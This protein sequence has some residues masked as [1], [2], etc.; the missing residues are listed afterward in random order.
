MRRFLALVAFTSLA[1]LLLGSVP[2]RAQQDPA[3]RALHFL[4]T[5]QAAD[6]HVDGFDPNQGTEDYLLAAAAGGY[7]P[8]ALRN[9]T[10]GKSGY[11]YLTANVAAAT[12]TAGRSGRLLQAVVVAGRPTLFAGVDLVARLETVLYKPSTGQYGDSDSIS[13][14]LAIVGLKAAGRPIPAAALTFLKSLQ[15]P[16]GSWYAGPPPV[17]PVTVLGDTN[18]TAFALVAMNA[19]GDHSR[20]SAALAYLHLQQQADGGFPYQALYPGSDPDSTGLV[21]EALLSAGQAPSFGAW[22]QPGGGNPYSWMVANQDAAS[23]GYLGYLGTP[24]SATTVQAVLGLALATVPVV[25][26]HVTGFGLCAAATS[27]VSALRFLA[28]QQAADGH[29]DGFSSTQ[30][31]EDYVLGAVAAG[32]DPGTLRAAS[33]TSAYDYLVAN[34]TAATATPG[35]T[36]RLLE[37]V[38][39]GGRSPVF[40]GVDLVGRLETTFY[41]STTGHY[42]DG[43]AFSQSLAMLALKSAGRPVPAQAVRFLK[44]L[45]NPDGSW[46]FSLTAGPGD[47]NDT[48]MA[49]M[50]LDGLGDHSTDASALAWLRTQQAAAADGGFPYQGAYPPSD[51]DSTGLVL[52]ALLAAAQ[53]PASWSV[54]GGTPISFLAHAQD[55]ASGGYLG[56]GGTPDAATTVPVVVA[57]ERLP[58]PILQPFSVGRGLSNAGPM[59]GICPSSSPPPSPAPLLSPPPIPTAAPTPAAIPTAAPEF[60]PAPLAEVASPT[61]SESPRPSPSPSLAAGPSPSPSL[62]PGPTVTPTTQ[63]IPSGRGGGGFPAPLLYGLAALGA[64]IVVGVGGAAYLFLVRR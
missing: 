15:N 63:A 28:S 25:S 14:G 8:N 40:G 2:G 49:L 42:G 46:Y 58:Y 22:A 53:D 11:D 34:V 48:A 45:E 54:T 6:G 35:G 33:G 30:G 1:L 43:D 18:S 51:P 16:D 7:D 24:D 4:A 29:V 10:S 60:S 31:T 5:Q 3:S 13:Q 64:L 55:A 38:R 32:Y 9:L 21:I 20:D 36:G 27:G 12:S 47:T 56:F 41:N 19:A 23:G 61:P 26:V 39:A 59:T 17:P 52:Q 57:L 44:S 62:Q 37:A 50:A